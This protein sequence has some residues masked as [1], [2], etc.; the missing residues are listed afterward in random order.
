MIKTKLF[1]TTKWHYTP[2]S[3][4]LDT[5]INNFFKNIQ[6]ETKIIDISISIDE[7]NL[8]ALVVFEEL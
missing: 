2:N 8:Y 5:I 4:Q 3:E 1:S 7:R 6:S